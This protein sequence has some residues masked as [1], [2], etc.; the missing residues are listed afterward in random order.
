VP[1]KVQ[2]N[3]T[4]L[5]GWR[6]WH[7]ASFAA[8]RTSGVIVETP[9]HE[10]ALARNA[11]LL[12]YSGAMGPDLGAVFDVRARRGSGLTGLVEMQDVPGAFLPAARLSCSIELDPIAQRL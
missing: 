9:S 3:A 4:P 11:I 5:S 12:Q 1:K 10:V 8:W 7:L 6:F 2:K